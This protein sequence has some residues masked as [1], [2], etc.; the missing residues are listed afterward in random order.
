MSEP[1]HHIGAPMATAWHLLRTL[2]GISV[3]SLW[4]LALAVL[5]LP[6]QKMLGRPDPDG[7]RAQRTVHRAARRYVRFGDWLG[8]VR[9]D[10]NVVTGLVGPGPRL[11]VVNHPSM[12]D[13]LVLVAWL[14]QVDCVV[15]TSWLRHPFLGRLVR[16][17]GHIPNEPGPA[18]VAECV[19]RLAAGRTLLIFPEG[20]RS[21][22]RGLGPFQRGAAHIALRSGVALTPVV[23]RW[24]PP[25]FT[26]G[27]SWYDSPTDRTFA[28]VEI[29]ERISPEG[30]A[31]A[32]LSCS[33]GARRLTAELRETFEKALEEQAVA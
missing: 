21:P 6:L 17:V 32:G 31:H 5:V 13:V 12:L 25:A 22:A 4:A 15:K 3:F 33:M 27:Q 10:S 29:L 19:E 1:A 26:R 30:V 18:A 11:L 14:P 23:L 9:L 8:F 7:R 2:I 28:T 20:T 24:E 16:T